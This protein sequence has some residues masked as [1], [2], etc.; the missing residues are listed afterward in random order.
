MML[1]VLAFLP[2]FWGIYNIIKSRKQADKEKHAYVVYGKIKIGIGLITGLF[3]TYVYTAYDFF[4][5]N[6]GATLA[7]VICWVIVTICNIAAQVKLGL[8]EYDAE[9]S[10]D[11][12]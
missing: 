9:H 3:L 6:F 11:K 2:M 4:S 10:A 12:K 5:S 7:I 1:I 8:E